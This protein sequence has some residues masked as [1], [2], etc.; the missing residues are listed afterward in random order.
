MSGGGGGCQPGA[1]LQ[2]LRCL[3][4]LL[5][6]WRI[7][8]PLLA[9]P[10]IAALLLRVVL[11]LLLA[12]PLTAALLLR[13]VLFLLGP[14]LTAPSLISPL[15]TLLIAA[16]LLRLLSLLLLLRLLAGCWR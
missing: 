5:G 7:G 3:G 11:Y 15:I 6:G 10:L 14:P 4:L 13:L 12:P 2:L 1:C 8:V 16:R 9:P